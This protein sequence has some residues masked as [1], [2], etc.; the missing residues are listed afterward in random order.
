MHS[1][2]FLIQRL[3]P[4][5]NQPL[6]L[7]KFQQKHQLQ[8]TPHPI[9]RSFPTKVPTE[10]PTPD[11][12]TS[13]PTIC[14]PSPTESVSKTPWPTKQPELKTPS[15]TKPDVDE[16]CCEK[17]ADEIIDESDCTLSKKIYY[18]MYLKL[19]QCNKHCQSFDTTRSS[20]AAAAGDCFTNWA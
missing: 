12:T 17:I 8:I 7:P 18:E 4:T 9:Q 20:S 11:P 10:T 5:R 14:T 2:P 19:F 15:P 1:E 13:D 6:S 3:H 16:S